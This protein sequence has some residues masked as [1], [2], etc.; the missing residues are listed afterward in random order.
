MQ[1][2]E[3][4]RGIMRTISVIVASA[5]L[6]LPGCGESN[7]DNGKE[8]GAGA[9]AGAEDRE[10]SYADKDAY[11]AKEDESRTKI[12]QVEAPGETFQIVRGG[13]LTMKIK[14]RRDPGFDG[15]VKLYVGTEVR[16]LSVTPSEPIIPR[17]ASEIELTFEADATA[18]DEYPVTIGGESES[19]IVRTDTFQVQVADP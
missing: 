6:V 15:P 16:G 17:E 18:I 13:K 11:D 8:A 19:G 9:T 14:I 1:P 12:A 2:H 4:H 3:R 5:A 10:A 7:S